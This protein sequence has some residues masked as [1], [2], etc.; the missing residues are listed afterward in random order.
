MGGAAT[1]IKWCKV[2][3]PWAAAGCGIVGAGIGGWAGYHGS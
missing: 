3:G 1:G 2:A